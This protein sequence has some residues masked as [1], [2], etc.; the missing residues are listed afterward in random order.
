MEGI[1]NKEI[2]QSKEPVYAQVAYQEGMDRI[3][4]VLQLLTSGHKRCAIITRTRQWGVTSRTIDKYIEEAKVYI[5]ATHERIMKEGLSG[6]ASRY[7]TL[8]KLCIE[9]GDYRGAAKINQLCCEMLFGKPTQTIKED[10]TN[11]TP[12]MTIISNGETISLSIEKKP[13]QATDET[14]EEATVVE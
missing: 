1:E 11:V 9:H 3:E 13:H 10:T 4:F 8:Y 14:T 7:E 12:T 2:E 5:R 6:F